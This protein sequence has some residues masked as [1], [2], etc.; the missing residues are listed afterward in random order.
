MV[1]GTAL[2]VYVVSVSAANVATSDWPGATVVADN[3]TAFGVAGVGRAGTV[4]LTAVD[5]SLVPTLL[6]ARSVTMYVV[7]LAK[8]VMVTGDVTE[9]GLR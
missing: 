1:R 2:I 5:G 8:P 3:L 9:A 7:P 4:T 6:T